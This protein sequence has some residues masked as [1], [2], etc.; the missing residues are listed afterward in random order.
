MQSPADADRALALFAVLARQFGVLA[1][2]L[3]IGVG[4]VAAVGVFVTRTYLSAW[5]KQRAGQSVAAALAT[6]R[7]EL[8][9]MLA[10]QNDAYA[11]RLEATRQVYREQQQRFELYTER[12]HLVYAKLY[13]RLRVAEGTLVRPDFE[14]LSDYATYT[15][16]ELRREA[17]DNRLNASRVAAIL[18]SFETGDRKEAANQFRRLIIAARKARGLNTHR[19]ATNYYAI[20]ELFLSGPVRNVVRT[21]LEAMNRYAIGLQAPDVTSGSEM[22]AIGE[23][24][25]AAVGTVRATMQKELHRDGLPVAPA[26]AGQ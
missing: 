2:L 14:F 13:R 8:D 26:Q 23:G 3:I 7:A 19:S 24:I 20:N 18:E 25:A 9:A 4:I 17:A 15:Q 12:Q 5:L 21:A 10:E 22:S 6:Q 11:R 16:S 1:A